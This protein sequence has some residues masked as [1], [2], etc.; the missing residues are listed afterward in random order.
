M[1]NLRILPVDMKKVSLW[2]ISTINLQSKLNVNVTTQLS[3]F[4]EQQL[5]SEIYQYVQLYSCKLREAKTQR[6]RVK[7][8]L[9]KFYPYAHDAYHLFMAIFGVFFPFSPFFP[10]PIRP[11]KYQAWQPPGQ[12]PAI[13]PATMNFERR[14][15]KSQRDS[16]WRRWLLI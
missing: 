10:I 5:L 13:H 7:S 1:K 3:H 15:G 9:T 8:P 4:I 6:A 16:T 14:L 11:A 2:C 12:P